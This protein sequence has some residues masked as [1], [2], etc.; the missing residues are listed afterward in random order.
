MIWAQQI[1]LRPALLQAHLDWLASNEAR[2]AERLGFAIGKTDKDFTCGPPI[3]EQAIQKGAAPL[4]RGYVRG[5]VSSQ[6]IPSDRLLDLVTQFEA[7][8]PEIAV[9]IL[10]F[11]GDRFDAL[12]R[13]VRLVESKAVPPRFLATFA[14]GTGGRGL[15]VD[16]VAR[17]LPYFIR[18]AVIGDADSAR[19]GIRFLA[20]H[21][22]FEKRRCE[23]SSLENEVVRSPVWGLMEMTLPF[24]DSQV[25]Y[26]WSGTVEQLAFYEA[27]RG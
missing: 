23:Q 17:L 20:W 21:Q 13:V 25:A 8:H 7:A 16:E 12:N 6:R 9:D 24:V 5:L 19:A 3:F 11:G 2:S 22:M 18:A 15:T 27:S 4:L 10:C 14:M 1:A 26:E